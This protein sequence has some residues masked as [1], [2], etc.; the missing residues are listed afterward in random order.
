MRYFLFAVALLVSSPALAQTADGWIS[1]PA[2]TTVT[3][4]VVLHYRRVLDL[5]TAPKAM[6]VTVTAD[7]RFILFVNGRRIATGPSTGT[8][9]HWRTE[10]VDL[11]R[12]LKR[13]RN[14]VAA[15]VWDFV[16]KPQDA[17]ANGPLPAAGAL[18]PQ[19]APIA[20]QSAGLGFR[21]T[22]GTI[23]TSEPGWRVKIDLGHTAV[24]G[25]LQVPRGRYYVASAPE[26]IDAA[27]MDWDWAGP[28]ETAFGWMDAVPAPGAARRTLVADSLP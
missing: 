23:S 16:R 25:R 18:P 3:Q 9:A 22:G 12:H 24:N 4:S 10:N 5:K 15:V 14:V 1:H 28:K 20:Q 6:P 27:A 21:L 11:A 19:V 2:A 26:V 7:N 13:G 17:P 8:I